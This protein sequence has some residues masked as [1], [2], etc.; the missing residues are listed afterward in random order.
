[1]SRAVVEDYLQTQGLPLPV[2]EVEVAYATLAAILQ[3][4]PN[5]EI[6]FNPWQVE[7]STANN[8]AEH[9]FQLQEHLPISEKTELTLKAI[10]AM[11]DS[12]TERFPASA[13]VFV[14]ASHSP[15]HLMRISHI[16]V[17]SAN[18]LLMDENAVAVEDVMFV[19]A[20]LTGWANVIDN[21]PQWV[22]WGDAPEQL[23]HYGNSH[24]SLPISKPDGAILGMVAVSHPDVS[25][26]SQEAQVWW[27]A[28]AI[29]LANILPAN[30]PEAWVY[31]ISE[32]EAD[33]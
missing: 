20:A 21:A 15:E 33:A 12:I 9:F 1:M 27:T 7:E 3:I 17:K 23:L 10:Y 13:R 14:R 28:L 25:G 30:L 2:E 31:Q 5:L 19:R 29:V 8:P 32:E 18:H 24:L 11:L 16:N 6:A 4:A 22:Q 26:L